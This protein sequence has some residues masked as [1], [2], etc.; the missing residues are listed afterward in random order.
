MYA[1]LRKGI[2]ELIIT[3]LVLFVHISYFL[4]VQSASQFPTVENG[5]EIWNTIKS[6]KSCCSLYIAAGPTSL[7]DYFQNGELLGQKAAHKSLVRQY[8]D[9]KNYSRAL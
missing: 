8:K 4:L 5:R 3:D 1:E 9:C 2:V 7:E 6:L